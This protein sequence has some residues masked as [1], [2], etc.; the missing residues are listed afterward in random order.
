MRLSNQL[1]V[2]INSPNLTTSSDSPLTLEESVYAAIESL[3]PDRA[4]T[5]VILICYWYLDVLILT[6]FLPVMLWKVLSGP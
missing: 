4:F 6:V 3:V 2:K 1:F 5:Y